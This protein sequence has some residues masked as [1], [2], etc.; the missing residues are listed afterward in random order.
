MVSSRAPT[1]RTPGSGPSRG[2]LRAAQCPVTPQRSH[3]LSGQPL[4]GGRLAQ[5]TSLWGRKRELSYVC[6]NRAPGWW[7]SPKRAKITDLAT[8][9]RESGGWG[10]GLDWRLEET[11]G[12]AFVRLG[13]LKSSCTNKRPTP[14]HCHQTPPVLAFTAQ[15]GFSCVESKASFLLS[16]FTNE[17]LLKYN[18]ATQRQSSLSLNSDK[19]VGRTC[20]RH[21]GL[22]FLLNKFVLEGWL[23]KEKA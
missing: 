4:W 8:Q 10:Q 22:I 21:S 20:G 12:P 16:D 2:G 11:K 18:L 23:L 7:F 14:A 19:N 5:T 9:H 3:K 6:T 15:L 1:R 17:C 13:K